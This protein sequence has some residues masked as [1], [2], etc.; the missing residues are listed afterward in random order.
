MRKAMAAAEVGDDVYGEDP[1][2][3]ALAGAHRR[4]AGQGSGRWVPTGTMANQIAIGS[5]AAWATRSSATATA[6]W[7]TTR[8][9]PSPRSGARTVPVDGRA[10]SSRPSVEAALRARRRAPRSAPE[11]GR[12]GEH[13]QPRRRQDLAARAVRRPSRDVAHAAGLA[14]H[15]DGARIWN[16]HVAT[17]IAAAE[18]VREGRH[19]LVCLSK[20]LGAPAGSLVA[21][22]AR[23]GEG[24]PR[25]CASAS[26]VGC[27]RRVCSRRRECT[28]STTI[29]ERLAEDHQSAKRLA[30][31]VPLRLACR[32]RPTS[33]SPT[34]Q[35]A[36]ALVEAARK[37][38]VLDQ[39]G[40]RYPH[41]RGDP[42]R[43]PSRAGG[44][45]R[46]PAAARGRPPLIDS[47]AMET[48]GDRPAGGHAEVRLRPRHADPRPLPAHLPR[49]LGGAAPRRRSS[50]TSRRPT[51]RPSCTGRS[52]AGCAA[53]AGARSLTISDAVARPGRRR[54]RA[55]G[56][57]TEPSLVVLKD[58]HAYLDNPAVV[59]ALR[60]LAQDLKSHLHDGDPALARRSPSRWSWRRRS[61]SSTCR[62]PPSAISTSCSRR[63][64]RWC[65]RETRR[66]VDLAR[67]QAE[68]L[69]KAA[70]GLTLS[71]AE[72][73]FAKAIANDG[74]LD[75]DDIAP[76]A[77]REAAGHPQERPARVRRRRG[78]ARHVGGLDELKGWLTGRDGAFGERGA[79]VRAARARRACCC[80]ACRA[81]ARASPPRRSPRSWALPL[82]RLDLG[83]IFSGLDRLAPRRTCARAIRVA[84]SVAPAVLWID[85]IEKGLAGNAGSAVTDGGVSAR[86]FGTLLTWMQ[87]KTAPVFVVATANR[88]EALPPELLR[89][90][91]FDEIFFVDLP[92]CA[93]RARDLPHPPATKAARPRAV[94]PRRARHLGGRLLGDGDRAGRDRRPVLRVRLR[95]RP[96]PGASGQ[97]GGGG[98]P[99]SSTMG[100]E[101]ARLREWSQNRTRPA[102]A[103]QRLAVAR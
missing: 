98:V 62:C 80:S 67:E 63:S 12:D 96:A 50:R 95:H 22:Y 39:R 84:E 92:S 91:R 81:A 73:A 32:R 72:N 42:S 75:K 30:A 18:L 100:E 76:G 61:P 2:V 3:N 71:E 6:T 20:G 99:L 68:Q 85:E 82:L 34:C 52:R 69:I 101:I 8:A 83:R 53:S 29:C 97:G 64:S 89:K 56:K 14:L 55:I 44:R 57:L 23:A 45:G 28:R 11:G 21:S 87:E 74:I 17:G 46:F 19:R 58:F 4:A 70:Q 33:F 43:F 51:A 36:P 31:A 37:E 40:E 13:A 15:L 88:I 16:A 79:Q 86:V 7:S 102:S 1:T 35:S 48:P 65:G 41:P 78:G 27:G 90:G 5:L 10:A 25:G 26:E 103:A 54:S 60:E 93:E 66:R 94:R 9:A 24:R 49:H 77:R 47:A 38:G 59:R